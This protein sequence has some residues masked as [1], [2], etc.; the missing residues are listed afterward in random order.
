MRVLHRN[1]RIVFYT[2][3][4]F[5]KIILLKIKLIVFELIRF[6]KKYLIILRNQRVNTE[7]AE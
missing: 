3:Y 7:T 4:K 6:L 5:G 2:T 1:N